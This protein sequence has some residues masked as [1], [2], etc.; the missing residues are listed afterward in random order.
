MTAGDSQYCPCNQSSDAATLP[1]PTRL[2]PARR[3]QQ[4]RRARV[5]ANVVDGVAVALEVFEDELGADVDDANHAREPRDGEHGVRRR[6]RF[7]PR[8]SAAGC[9]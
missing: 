3:Q 7:A 8:C 5:R 2:V 6:L 4:V 1:Q 9:I